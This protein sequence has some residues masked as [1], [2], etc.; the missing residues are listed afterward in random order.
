MGHRQQ[1]R[2]SLG[3]KKS[4]KN[5]ILVIRGGGIGDFILTL[6]AIRLLR[7]NFPH[8]HLEVLG[9]RRVLALV[10]AT[11]H[12]DG[13]RSIDYGP[14]ASCF[15]PAAQVRPDLAAYFSEFG[16]IVSY[17]YD[18]DQMFERTLLR[19]GAQ[20]VLSISPQLDATA[21]AA[22]Q[23][24]KPLEKLALFLDTPTAT[25]QFCQADKDEADQRLGV[26]IGTGIA[27]H[28]GSGGER[29][30]WTLEGWATVIEHL[31]QQGLPV[32]L[33]AGEAD[34]ERAEHLQSRFGDRLRYLI[35]LPLESLA[36]CLSRCR[37][38]L[39]QDTG[40]SHLAA[41]AE[42]RCLLLF[43]PTNPAVWAP[44]NPGVRILEAPGK[45]LANLQP[46]TVL[47]ALDELR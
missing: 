41:A 13:T 1:G 38:F 40:I 17:I 44:A 25:L 12:A 5:R 24:A 31:L 34:Q 21:H 4:V 42:C 6:P 30:N 16:Q 18:P 3:F 15:N 36:A 9:Y 26:A 23:L 45:D 39:G 14:M 8:C 22:H 10:Q 27:I 35:D 11:G 43:G 47:A 46:E 19:L 2:R 37:H 32:F 29:K 20:N 7:D 28:P 33:V